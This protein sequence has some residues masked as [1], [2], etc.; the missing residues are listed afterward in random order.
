MHGDE[1]LGGR[2]AARPAAPPSRSA[3]RDPRS[4]RRRG[5][6]PARSCWSPPA[7]SRTWRS[8]LAEEPALPSLLR[9][10]A[11][12][13][14]AYAQAGNVDAGAPR[15]TS[16]STP[17]PPQACSR[18]SR[19]PTQLPVCVGLDVTEQVGMTRED[20]E[21]V[22]APAPS[23]SPLAGFLQDAVAL[24]HRLLRP[25]PGRARRRMHDPLALAIAHRSVA[26][27]LRATRVEVECD[28]T[29]DPRH[30]RDRPGRDAADPVAGVGAA[31]ENARVALAVD[32]PALH[33]PVLE[34]LR[35]RWSGA[36]V[37]VPTLAVVGA[38][39]VDLVVAGADAA[40]TGRDR[41][42]R[43]RSRSTTAARAATRRWR[44]RG[45]SRG[46]GRWS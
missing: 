16:G 29:L 34:R 31:A 37:S 43:R 33:A 32:A 25:R 26:R 17:R 40:G 46:T 2:D 44:P 36:R 35:D 30:D 5:A 11:L 7:R 3:R 9:G 4:S 21:A 8:P 12:M 23:S 1:G 14:G 24:L 13:G 20:V 45:R 38:I 10:F 39:N 27:R 18:R 19:A 15:R 6:V 22:C 41:R 42:R 28:G